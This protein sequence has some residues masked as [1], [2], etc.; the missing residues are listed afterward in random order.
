MAVLLA[1]VVGLALVLCVLGL[2]W[3]TV[4]VAVLVLSGAGL[5]ALRLSGLDPV[6][7]VSTTGELAVRG[8]RPVIALQGFGGLDVP[9][10][11]EPA[12]KHGR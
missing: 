2:A 12:P 11:P 7:R 4:A 9:A 1:A 3:V 10:D 5:A 6:G 8:R